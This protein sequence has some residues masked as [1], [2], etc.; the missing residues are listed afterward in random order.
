VL[1]A[2]PI[3]HGNTV[4]MNFFTRYRHEK[5]RVLHFGVGSRLFG[6]ADRRRAA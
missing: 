6:G 5:A 1:D 3:R 2:F 4:G